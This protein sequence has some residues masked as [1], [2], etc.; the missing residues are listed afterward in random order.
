MSPVILAA[1][2]VSFVILIAAM[3]VAL[4]RLWVGPSVPDRAAALDLIS[5]LIVAAVITYAIRKNDSMLMDP[6]IVL[7]V[8]SFLGTVAFAKYLESKR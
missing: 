1:S 2:Q 7:A 3:L 4:V 8:I 6:V 5:M